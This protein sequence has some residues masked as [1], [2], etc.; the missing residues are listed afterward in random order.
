[1]KQLFNETMKG[2]VDK[3][4]SIDGTGL[5]VTHTFV[6]SHRYRVT[7]KGPGGHSYGELVALYVAGAFDT[8][9]LWT[10]SRVRG[11]LM[12]GQG[13]RGT[14]AAVAGPL[15]A[16]AEVLRGHPE[17][18]LANRNH[19]EQGVISGARAAVARASEALNAKGLATKELGVSAAFHSPLVADAVAP[20]RSALASIAV[21]PPSIR[22][23]SNSTAQPYPGT[24]DAIRGET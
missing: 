15:A 20:F 6:G 8:E 11:E 5:S 13:D 17:V 3:F 22:V 4:V 16:I 24:P 10:A 9:A 14:M 12:E 18:V 23:W 19:R 21:N 7:F 1:M 2:Q